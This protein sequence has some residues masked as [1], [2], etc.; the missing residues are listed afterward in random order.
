ML[1]SGG[2]PQHFFLCLKE[3]G[4]GIVLRLAD[5]EELPELAALLP[6]PNEVEALVNEQLAS[7]SLFAGLFRENA[8]RA[9]L[10][11]RWRPGARTPLW[12]QRLKAQ[13][14]LAA[15]ADERVPARDRPLAVDR[16]E[17]DIGMDA[18]DRVDAADG[19][20]VRETFPNAVPRAVEPRLDVLKEGRPRQRARE[21]R[22]PSRRG[23]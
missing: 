11:P 8:V 16:G 7:S 12:A 20:V 5:V 2:L 1:A 18:G 15:P 4:D 10:L 3:S 14:L 9:L 6:D 19:Q 21:L 13:R 17:V 23:R 22:E